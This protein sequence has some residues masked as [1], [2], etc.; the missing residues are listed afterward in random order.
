MDYAL[1]GKM[2]K[3]RRY[4]EDRSRFRFDTFAL[5]FHGDNNE[6]RVSFGDGAFVCDCEFFGSHR[7]CGHTMALE[8]L[9]KDMIRV[10][11]EADAGGRVGARSH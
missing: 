2:D 7:R 9:L 11:S 3:A 6:H 5:T 1:I 10:S 4:A 8:I